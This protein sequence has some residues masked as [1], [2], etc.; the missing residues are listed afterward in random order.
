MSA[1]IINK[2]DASGLITIDPAEYYT[3]GKRMSF[4]IKPHLLEEFLLREKDFRDFI[5]TN[6]WS[7]FQ[8]AYVSVFCS[9]DAIIPNWAYMLLASAMQPFAK[10]IVFGTP[11]VLESV[12]YNEKLS[13]LDTTE[14]TGKRIVIKGCGDLPVP[15]FAYV[16]LTN[17]LRPV[18][19]S[20]MY[21]EPC[22]TVPVYKMK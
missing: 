17:R 8:D 7:V 21:G 9:N 16:E 10:R 2:V 18:V 20:I 6:D 4:D 19:K 11:E 12:L 14:L 13:K 3:D 15:V 22:S 1:E 5:K